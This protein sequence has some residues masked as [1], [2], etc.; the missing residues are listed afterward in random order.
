ME[1]VYLILQ[2][3]LM[4]IRKQGF[5]IGDL[6]SRTPLPLVPLCGACGL[7]KDCL[8]PKMPVY[9]K[10]NKQILVIGDYPGQEEDFQ[11]KP[12]VG[13]SGQLLKDTLRR[14]GIELSQD[15]WVSN[16]LICKPNKKT[17]DRNI[18]YCRPNIVH[19]IQHLKPKATLLVGT[20][21]VQSV[22]GWSWK[23]DPGG[24]S[25]WA[26]FTIPDRRIN[27]WI[28]PTFNPAFIMRNK[29]DGKEQDPA[30]II[31]NRHLENFSRLEERPYESV[32]DDSLRIRKIMDSDKAVALL[33]GMVASR[34]PLAFDYET[35]MIKPDDDMARIVCC[36]FSDGVSSI[37][38]PWYGKVR[39]VVREV[40]LDPSVAKVG[41][42]IKFEERWTCKEFGRSVANWVF[43]GMLAAHV[44]DSRKGTKSL[45]F[46]SYARLGVESYNDAIEPYLKSKDGKGG[47]SPNNIDDISMSALLG[48]CAEDSLREHQLAYVLAKELGIKL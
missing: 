40:L 47:N 37:A 26:G 29:K 23:G 16:A 10:G 3:Q 11:G 7:Y 21:A 28:C 44:L 12:F 31:W 30:E 27:A 43:D 2:A 13:K 45:K 8:S 24:I 38:F 46:Q 19:L 33:K 35:S 4:N 5:F 6:V 15:C 1:T 18:D 22:I 17:K 14:Y 42:N 36:S 32:P 25:R 9:G 39:D 41:W 34:V 20:G 48:Y